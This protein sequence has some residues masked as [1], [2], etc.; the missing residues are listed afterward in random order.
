MTTHDLQFQPPHTGIVYTPP[1]AS[2]HVA[3]TLLLEYEA[4]LGRPRDAP[5]PQGHAFD[6]KTKAC[7]FRPQAGIK[8][9]FAA[10]PKRPP[11]AEGGG[12][13]SKRPCA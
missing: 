9:F 2:D 12:S 11:A 10:Q 13:S 1:A 5:L 6:A 4:A 7:S 8:S 3:T